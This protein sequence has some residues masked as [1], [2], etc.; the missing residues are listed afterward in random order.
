MVENGHNVFVT[1]QGGTGKL[2]LLKETFRT[3]TSR[4]IRCAIVCVSGISGTV[5]NGLSKSVSTV[6]AFYSLQAADL[7]WKLIVQSS[8]A[9]NLVRERLKAAQCIIW[10]EASMS[11][12]HILELANYIH[13]VLATKGQSMKPEKVRKFHTSSAA[14]DCF[15]VDNI[16]VVAKKLSR[17]PA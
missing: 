7:P 5:Y 16:F 4:G 14:A 13:H 12:R 3:L 10:D 6:H 8:T 15:M 11:S 2:F 1:R 17:G 9:H